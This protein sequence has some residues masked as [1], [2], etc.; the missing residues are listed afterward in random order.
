MT[1]RDPVLSTS[2]TERICEHMNAE[3]ADD[4]LRMARVY[5]SAPKATLARMTGMDAEGMEL[6]AI[7]DGAAT[8]LRV[9]F[10]DPVRTVEDARRTLVDMALQA[11]EASS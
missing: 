6:A 3:H 9:S 5:G 1:Q 7:V 2:D 10:E 8:P 11:R 4:L